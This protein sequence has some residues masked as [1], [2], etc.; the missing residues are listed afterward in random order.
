MKKLEIQLSMH[1]KE[2]KNLQQMFETQVSKLNGQV[3][4]NEATI[5]DK[6]EKIA[7]LIH[8]KAMAEA[9]IN[10]LNQELGNNGKELEFEKKVR[11]KL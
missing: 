5:R 2:F 10:R 11:Q 3:A 7:D 8:W 1:Q 6:E 4:E 9:E